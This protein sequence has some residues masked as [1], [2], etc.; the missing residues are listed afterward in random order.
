ML[1][2]MAV[3]VAVGLQVLDLAVLERL[4]QVAAAVVEMK[5]QKGLEQLLVHLIYQIKDTLVVL[6][7][8]IVP[9]LVVAAAVLEG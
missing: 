5:V 9:R 8:G 7:V 3:A 6:E 2:Q 1:F 4:E